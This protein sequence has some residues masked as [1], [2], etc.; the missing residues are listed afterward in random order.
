LLDSRLCGNDES[1]FTVIPAQAGIQCLSS[2]RLFLKI[3][4]EDRFYFCWIPAYAGMTNRYSPSFPRRRESSAFH[5][6]G[7]SSKYFVKIAFIF[8]GFP[9]T[10]E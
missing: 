9:P 1:L 4:C 5:Q 7:F 3:F 10:R 6:T 8:A 2:N